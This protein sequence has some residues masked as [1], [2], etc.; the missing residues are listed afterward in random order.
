MNEKRMKEALESIARRGMPE[1]VNLM[2]GIAARLERKSLMTTLRARPILLILTI[3]L[4]LTLLTGVAYAIGRLTGFIPGIGFVETSALRVLAEP[5]SV[6]REGITLTVEQVV[7]SAD[8]TV[9]L[10][11]VEGIPADAYA[12]EGEGGEPNS[13]SSSIV[14]QEGT[15]GVEYS[16]N[17][18]TQC[19]ADERLILPDGA[20]VRMRGGGM[21]GWLT[22]F[23]SRYEYA[24]LPVTVNQAVF[25]V[26]CIDGTALGRLPENWE[27][28]L[29]FVPAPPD[30]TIFPVLDVTATG[31]SQRALTIE[32]VIETD[33]GY[34][35]MGKFRLIGYPS[36]VDPN[37]VQTNWVKFTD[38]EG[39]IVDAFPFADGVQSEI[40]L[41]GEF[42]W[43]YKIQEKQP[44]WPLTITMDAVYANLLDTTAEFEFDTGNN[45]LVG[46]TWTLD[47]DVEIAGYE[48]REVSIKRT[49][50]GYE[51][52]FKVEPEILLFMPEIKGFPP[53]RGSGGNDG[54]GAGRIY[55]Q[56][57]YRNPPSGKL[58]VR[59][60]DVSV[61]V[62]GPWQV[63]WSPENTPSTP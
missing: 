4:A 14:V 59:L 27:I 56:L 45:P 62:H 19:F 37:G 11:R 61:V 17:V 20:I 43:S 35:L 25:I 6:T 34:I 48:I 10:Y 29:R 58:T 30:M 9:L 8:K 31:E 63:K 7:L 2:P 23:E 22:G 51:F 38:R 18:S 1:D 42:T 44:A 57:E 50:S 52:Q 39:R 32:K 55:Y 53:S 12:S 47:P 60:S 13:V 36:N 21:Y 24:S 28:P 49:E 5:V 16:S 3:L 54:F 41:P 40:K 15:P 33:D 26:S 46:Q